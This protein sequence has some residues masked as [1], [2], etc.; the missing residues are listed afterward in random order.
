[1]SSLIIMV[2]EVFYDM[3]YFFFLFFL[4]LTI[5]AIMINYIMN[6]NGTMGT[7]F[8]S[9]DGTADRE[10][11]FAHIVRDTYLMAIG[12]E[13]N[14]EYGYGLTIFIGSS[15]LFIVVLLN[16]L[17]AVVGDTFDKVQEN[18]KPTRYIEQCAL[19]LDFEQL[20]FW[21]RNHG[22]EMYFHMCQYSTKGSDNEM[23]GSNCLDEWTGKM[24]SLKNSIKLIDGTVQ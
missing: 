24:R 11:S 7:I 23:D 13:S 6:N 18:R 8:E 19:M 1:M 5:T 12:M 17:I 22:V 4:F 14:G 10:A 9:D 3:R 15:L 20:C 21:R 16:L 2:K